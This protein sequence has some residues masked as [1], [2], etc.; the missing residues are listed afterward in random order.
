MSWRKGSTNTSPFPDPGPG[1]VLV[2]F[3]TECGRNPFTCQYPRLTTIPFER[4][5]PTHP[6]GPGFLPPEVPA[7]HGRVSCRT[8]LPWTRSYRTTWEGV[9]E[10][11]ETALKC[12]Y[13]R[14]T[15]QRPGVP[16]SQVSPK[17]MWVR[18]SNRKML[19]MDLGSWW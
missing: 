15:L 16:V 18:D 13:C 19:L 10:E 8:C 1:E 17:W 9:R 11:T 4:R 7:S 3:T 12:V 5:L 6:R 2:S 14:Q